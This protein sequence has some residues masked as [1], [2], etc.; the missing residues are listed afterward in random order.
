MTNPLMCGLYCSR[1]N[2][3]FRLFEHVFN[4]FKKVY[5]NCSKVISYETAVQILGLKPWQW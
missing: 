2:T 5:Q 3:N 4:L 1:S